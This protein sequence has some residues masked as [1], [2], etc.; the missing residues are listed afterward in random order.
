MERCLSWKWAL[1]LA[2]ILWN[3]VVIRT[4][5]IF[6]FSMCKLFNKP[7]TQS[8]MT[9]SLGI[10]FDH[11]PDGT[12][13]FYQNI[14]RLDYP[15]DIRN[16]RSCICSNFPSD[17]TSFTYFRQKIQ[18]RIQPLRKASV[19]S[20]AAPRPS[21]KSQHTHSSPTLFHLVMSQRT[22]LKQSI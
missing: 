21:S 13:N 9:G 5:I 6:V 16:V 1:I 17:L 7:V 18:R 10:Q 3:I 15:V 12:E 20:H 4:G 11:S 22:H 2:V 14:S 19:P 8:W